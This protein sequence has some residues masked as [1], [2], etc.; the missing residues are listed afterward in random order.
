MNKERL[1]KRLAKEERRNSKGHVRNLRKRLSL[2]EV[3]TSFEAAPT[4]APV[5]P[6]ASKPKKTTKK[7]S[8]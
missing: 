6:K 7:K 8:E 4:S 2:A 1:L 3:E 5:K